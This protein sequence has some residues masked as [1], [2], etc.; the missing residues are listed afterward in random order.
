MAHL[1]MDHVENWSLHNFPKI[2]ISEVVKYEVSL[3]SNY[4]SYIRTVWSC[5]ENWENIKKNNDGIE[6][7]Q[8]EESPLRF[9]WAF[10]QNNK[11]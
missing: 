10:R 2:S 7:W 1:K 4:H 6:K 9:E 5:E 11:F 3:S 8:C